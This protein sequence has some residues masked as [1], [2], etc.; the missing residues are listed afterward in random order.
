MEVPVLIACF[1]RAEKLREVIKPLFHVA[2]PIY[3]VIDAPRNS[4]DA[5]RIA[6]VRKVLED[7]ELNVRDILTFS[8][9]QGTNSVA[10]G[11]DW[12]LQDFDSVIVIE[13][14]VLISPQFIEFAETML[15]EYSLDYRVGSITAMN[16]VPISHVTSPKSSYRFS[17]YF[18]AWGWA[19]WKDRW[20][21]MIPL[22]SWDI[23]SVRTPITAR[24]PLARERWKAGMREV[25]SGRAPGL[26]DY[27]WIY[28]YWMKGW[29]TIVPNVNLALNIGFDKE[30][31]HTRQEPLWAPSKIE[32]LPKKLIRMNTPRQ[33]VTADRWSARF[34]HNTYWLTLL[35]TKIKQILK[36]W[37]D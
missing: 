5:L 17:C 20:T 11:I 13:E 36:K 12:I 35:K 23:D 29:L 3:V 18:Y 26:W 6:E 30:A 27:R 4:E 37:A 1:V 16:L 21:Q 28:T 14:D 31:T 10:M 7:S 19:T 2:N 9:N 32:L 24:G 22:D 33:D 15:E 34:V 25:H 8:V